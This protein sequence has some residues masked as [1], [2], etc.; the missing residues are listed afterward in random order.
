MP[1]PQDAAKKK[2]MEAIR[3]KTDARRALNEAIKS[4]SSHTIG[5]KEQNKKLIAL[6]KKKESLIKSEAKPKGVKSVMKQ[7]AKARRGL[8][9]RAH[10]KRITTGKVGRRMAGK[11]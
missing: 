3:K 11:R 6:K 9:V 7:S 1:I 10:L 5:G 8:K 2:R 4:E